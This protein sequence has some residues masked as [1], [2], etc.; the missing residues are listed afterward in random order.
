MQK[1]LS[2]ETNLDFLDQYVQEIPAYLDDVFI[3]IM[4][5]WESQIQL[6]IKLIFGWV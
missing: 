3:S 6:L 4:K 5:W 1:D 2:N